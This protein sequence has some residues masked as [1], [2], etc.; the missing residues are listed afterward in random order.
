[1]R[2]AVASQIAPR[3]APT[4]KIET[5]IQS[6]QWIGAPIGLRQVPNSSSDYRR[7]CWLRLNA[8]HTSALYV[9]LSE[10][11]ELMAK[12]DLPPLQG[13]GEVPAKAYLF[14]LRRCLC[15]IFSDVHRC[16]PIVGFQVRIYPS[17]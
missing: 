8:G 2:F 14:R 6:A 16:L 9:R 3:H 13:L 10:S 12:H 15:V 7:D 1:M 5:G 17:P 4:R 11:G